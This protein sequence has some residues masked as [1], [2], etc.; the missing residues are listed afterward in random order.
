MNLKEY[1][2]TAITDITSA[3]SELQGELVNGAI[4]SPQLQSCKDLGS[5]EYLEHPYGEDYIMKVTNVNFDVATTVGTTEG[6][7]AGA[8]L[9]ISVISAGIGGS[10]KVSLENASRISFSIPVAFP[11]RPIRS[12]KKQSNTCRVV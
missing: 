12:G 2:K 1:I 5:E 11:V 6:K 3:I 10:N 8:E 7:K 4:V 9:N